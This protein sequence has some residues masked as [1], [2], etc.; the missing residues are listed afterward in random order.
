[1]VVLVMLACSSCL[2]DT[3][4]VEYTEEGPFK[5]STYFSIRYLILFYCNNKWNILFYLYLFFICVTVESN[6]NGK[7]FISYYLLNR[8]D[9][10]SIGCGFTFLNKQQLFHG[11]DILIPGNLLTMTFWATIYVLESIINISIECVSFP[12]GFSQPC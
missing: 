4:F 1:M 2:L 3:G 5:I 8:C 11:A 10:K 12:F 7:L 6:I 9:H